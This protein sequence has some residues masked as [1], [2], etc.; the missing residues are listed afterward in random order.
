MNAW[1]LRD[2]NQRP[3]SHCRHWIR[4]RVN[5]SNLHPPRRTTRRDASV[6]AGEH[7]VARISRRKHTRRATRTYM[8]CAGHAILRCALVVSVAT[9]RGRSAPPVTVAAVP[10]TASSVNIKTAQDELA[11]VSATLSTKMERLRAGNQGA[12]AEYNKAQLAFTKDEQ[13]F[14]TARQKAMEVYERSLRSIVQGLDASNATYTKAASKWQEH[15]LLLNSSRT[16]LQVEHDAALSSAAAKLQAALMADAQQRL[17]I[18]G[19]Q[20]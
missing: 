5:P 7:T 2:V 8:G 6:P 18:L 13:D 12:H 16:G 11:T 20:E 15:L 14:A 1:Q 10:V 19:V 4:P 17:E 3:H 9:A